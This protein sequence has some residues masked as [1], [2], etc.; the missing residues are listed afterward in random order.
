MSPKYPKPYQSE[1]G[2]EK[3]VLDL[4]RVGTRGYGPGVRQL[5][6]RLVASVPEDV[7]DPKNFRI[8]VHEAMA[9]E[10]RGT[11][12]RF[13]SGSIPTEDDSGQSLV[14]VFPSPDGSRLVLNPETMDQLSEIVEE[15]IHADELREAGVGLTRTI[16]FSG[17]PGT[18][19]TMAASWLAQSLELPLLSLNLSTAVSSYLGSSGKNIKAALDYATTGPCVLL[20][21]EFDAIAKRRDDETDIGELKRI[22]NVILVELDQWPDKSL[23]VAATN[24]L[25][26]LDPAIERRFDRIFSLTPPGFSERLEI[27]KALAKTDDEIGH[28]TL[29]V[30][31]ALTANMT[32]AEIARSWNLARRR[33][34]LKKSS[35]VDLFMGDLANRIRESGP[36]RDRLCLELSSKMQLSNRRIATILGVSHPTVAAAIKRAEGQRHARISTN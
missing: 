21:D 5:A 26:L 35:T 20:L 7:K 33:S 6:S 16:L 10:T 29:G 9:V 18:G 36:D 34:I 17:P 25:H 1:S 27:V 19:K 30:L 14:N 4:I 2:L 11:E 23:L 8:A 32:G 15:R 3:V 12:L 31:S 28:D 13:D 22:V 24:H